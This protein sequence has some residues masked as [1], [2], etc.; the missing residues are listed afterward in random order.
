MFLTRYLP[1]Y[2]M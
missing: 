1:L 2:L